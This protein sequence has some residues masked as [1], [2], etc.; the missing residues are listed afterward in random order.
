MLSEMREEVIKVMQNDEYLSKLKCEKWYEMEDKLVKLCERVSGKRDTTYDC[1]D[2]M[3]V[4]EI[5][6]EWL[7]GVASDDETRDFADEVLELEY[8]T[9]ASVLDLVNKYFRTY[10]TDGEIDGLAMEIEEYFEK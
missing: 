10:N 1:K 6:E 2:I 7:G 8:K 3:R 4:Q 5:T 9:F